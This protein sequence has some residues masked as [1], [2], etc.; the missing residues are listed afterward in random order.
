MADVFLSQTVNEQL[1][2]LPNDVAN[3]IRDKLRDAGE[4]PDRQ[5]R[6]MS[7]RDDY[8]IRVGDYRALA[9]WDKADDA[10]YVTEIGHRR[11]VYD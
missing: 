11:N 9:D 5:L 8:S 1:D 2:D 7:G 4:R 3:R 6:Q 10:I